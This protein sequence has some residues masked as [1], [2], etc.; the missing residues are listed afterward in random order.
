MINSDTD[1][2]AAQ[3]FI[4]PLVN[5]RVNSEGK[6]TLLAG[7]WSIV[8]EVRTGSLFVAGNWRIRLLESD[9]PVSDY[10]DDDNDYDMAIIL[11][12]GGD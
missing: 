8:L 6:H 4:V 2:D 12:M 9:K 5:V 7:I 10:E 1:E 3:Y 11:L